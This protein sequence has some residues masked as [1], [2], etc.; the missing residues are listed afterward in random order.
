MLYDHEADADIQDDKAPDHRN[1][2]NG[3]MSLNCQIINYNKKYP[4]FK[5][6]LISS[7]DD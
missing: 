4:I 7:F 3:G 6:A 2:A 1:Q 5:K